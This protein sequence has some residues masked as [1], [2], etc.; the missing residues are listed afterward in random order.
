MFADAFINSLSETVRI[1]KI[2]GGYDDDVLY[3]ISYV[4]IYPYMVIFRLCQVQ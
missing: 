2:W 1:I 4:D 3:L